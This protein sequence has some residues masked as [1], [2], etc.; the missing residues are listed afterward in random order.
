MVVSKR[1]V[2]Y[3]AVKFYVIIFLHFISFE[4]FPFAYV[5]RSCCVKL[6]SQMKDGSKNET[7]LQKR[8]IIII[9]EGY[10]KN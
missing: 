1:A 8:L 9:F 6:M 4:L 3:V 7:C 10:S 5:V 2:L